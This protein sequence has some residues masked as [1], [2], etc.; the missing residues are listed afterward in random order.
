M[1]GDALA[2]VEIGPG[3]LVGDRARAV[4]DA[5]G[6]G[7]SAKYPK[8]WP[9]L[10]AKRAEY[11]EEPS[12]ARTPPAVRLTL[13]GSLSVTSDDGALPRV[14]SDGSPAT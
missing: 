13:P 5:D 6:R 3:G 1:I 14:L 2:S 4:V 7:G 9:G 12:T 10:F 8:R 11:P